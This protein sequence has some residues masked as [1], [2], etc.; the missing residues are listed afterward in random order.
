MAA[1]P[2]FEHVLKVSVI[3]GRALAIQNSVC[4]DDNSTD[5]QHLEKLR[6]LESVLNTFCYAALASG[7]GV[8][9]TSLMHLWLRM[10]TQC[11]KILMHHPP[12]PST[13]GLCDCLEPSS[14]SAS[15]ARGDTECVRAAMKAATTFSHALEETFYALNNP[16]L[17]PI[18]CTCVRMITSLRNQMREVDREHIWGLVG[19]ILRAVDH[20][21]A[22][23]PGAAAKARETIVQ[24]VNELEHG[25]R[26]GS[27]SCYVGMDCE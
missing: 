22:K 7:E 4:H 5:K 12:G 18:A 2:S 10:L 11:T 17:L 14:R 24:R 20:I 1:K 26:R 8:G 19:E 3:L 13:L 6:T 15:P 27:S 9:P 23:F 16:F 25:A 21:S